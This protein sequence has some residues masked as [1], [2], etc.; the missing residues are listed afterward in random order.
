M[1][2]QRGS[3]TPRMTLAPSEV[4]ACGWVPAI[5]FEA[6][7]CA[8]GMKVNLRS[9]FIG[10]K[11]KVLSGLIRLFGVENFVFVRVMLPLSEMHM[12]SEV[13]KDISEEERKNVMHN[14]NLWGLTLNMTSEML[15]S[16]GLRQTPFT[17][18]S[19]PILNGV[20]VER[21]FDSRVHNAGVALISSALESLLGRPL[22]WEEKITSYM[23]FVV[24]GIPLTIT[25]GTTIAYFKAKL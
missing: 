10:R 3:S 4:A 5:H 1:Y 9:S 20:E 16:T 23:S 11:R 25:A 8:S 6:D 21:V 14:F 2:Y 22:T 15:T 7:T 12:P 19:A 24:I 13:E 17:L 18:K